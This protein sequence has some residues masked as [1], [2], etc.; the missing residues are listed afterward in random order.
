MGGGEDRRI[1]L[2]EVCGRGMV[3]TRGDTVKHK[4]KN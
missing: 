1:E 4:G 3:E 2:G